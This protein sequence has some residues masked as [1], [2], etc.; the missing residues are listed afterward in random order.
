MTIMS[1]IIKVLEKM[2]DIYTFKVRNTFVSIVKNLEAIKK[3]TH[4][5]DYIKI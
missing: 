5:S 4:R 2:W 1:K 3:I